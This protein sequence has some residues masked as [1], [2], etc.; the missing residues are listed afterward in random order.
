MTETCG[1]RGNSRGRKITIDPTWDKYFNNYLEVSQESF[2]QQFLVLFQHTVVFKMTSHCLLYILAQVSTISPCKL[3]II[4][5]CWISTLHWKELAFVL[6]WN[7]QLH[8]RLA[9]FCP[10]LTTHYSTKKLAFILL[11]L[12]WTR[13]K[14]S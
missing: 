1:H 3:P 2:T 7:L 5:E 13:V 11:H 10:S 4:C 12:G 9:L 8:L 6:N 14:W